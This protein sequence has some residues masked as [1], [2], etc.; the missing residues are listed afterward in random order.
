MI[1]FIII[2]FVILGVLLYAYYETY[3]ANR[4]LLE[5]K[6]HEEDFQKAVGEFE[7][8]L[9]GTEYFNNRKYGN[10]DEG[11]KWLI[12]MIN[13]DLSKA[14]I[15]K[16]LKELIEK[17]LNYNNN[18]RKIIDEYNEKFV[19]KESERILPLLDK[20][21][22]KSDHDQRKSIVCEEDRTLVV[23]GAGTGKTQ[24]ILGKVAYLYL[25]KKVHPEEILLLSFTKKAAQELKT[26]TH[27]ISD[28][29]NVGTFNG[30]G[31]EIIGKMQGK[32]P[33]VAFE[34]D[35]SYQKF[36][37]KIFNSKLKSDNKFLGLAINY[38]LYYLYPVELNPGYETKDAYYKSLKAGNILTIKKEQVKSIH[39]A[40][41]ANFLYAHKINYEYERKYEYKTSNSEH[42]QYKPDFYLTDYGIYL[43]HF[44][45][46]R[47]G[48]THFTNNEE[49]N[50]IDSIKYN[51]DIDEKRSIHL[52]NKTKLIETYSYEFF[53]GNWQE[54]LIEKLQKFEIILEKR[55]ESEILE[56][57][58][59]GEY[60]R[61]I[62]PL[63]CTFLNLMKS[64]NC[65]IE[66]IKDQFE[67]NKDERGMAFMKIFEA[68]YE[69][70]SQHLKDNDEIDFNDMLLQ[71]ADY[72]RENKCI[73]NYKYIIIDEFQDFSFSKHKLIRAMLSQNPN[74]KLYC[75]GDDWQ[76]IYRFSGSDVNLMLHFEKY[77]GFTKM[78]LLEKCHRF[79]NQLAEITNNFILIN[80][81]Q[82]K[83][84]LYSDVR[85]KTY[86]LQIQF[87]KND[88][89]M[90]ALKDILEDINSLAQKN[91]TI[92]YN[93]LL[94][95]RFHHNKP[96]SIDY[97][98]HKGIKIEFMTIHQAKGLT[99]DYAIILNNETGKYGFPS[100]F[101]DDPLINVVLS[102]VDPSPHSEERRLMYVA[103][104]RAK[105]KVFLLTNPK[106]KS[107][108]I[109]ELEK[110]N[111]NIEN[112]KLCRE[113]G[114]E[115]VE[116]DSRYGKFYGCSNFPY[117][118]Y[119]EKICRINI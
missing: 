19:E 94:L 118:K 38:F 56:E 86:P 32:R 49:Q 81:H 112:I 2:L 79:N 110:K 74:T 116:R 96:K 48:N 66:E 60:I 1:E 15:E 59:K 13:F 11:H 4:G 99:C 107:L 71:A 93:V 20:L 77:F 40:M 88:D 22:I 83:K 25:D 104:T 44:G 105:N 63:I 76:S 58:K 111:Q 91:N 87:E 69:S 68:I 73:H 106:N 55:S 103:M 92:V 62:T 5:M 95:G 61:L 102:E 78:L 6:Q 67:K 30:V 24:T 115:M 8:F 42:S 109:R 3:K 9:D 82:L 108:F 57:I 34:D 70:Y 29:L 14:T 28:E 10:W 43:E 101:A 90:S 97:S 31:Y 12:E 51:V 64:R 41:I 53:E 7:S 113:C 52:Q 21:E 17:Y 117:C 27:Q 50:K 75:V 85:A 26:R 16:N 18:A 89:G 39:E 119:K 33:S 54:R 100:E 37:N 36:I 114:G 23:A 45:I 72:V 80:Q 47:K 35:G 46:D 65:S 98:I 84:K